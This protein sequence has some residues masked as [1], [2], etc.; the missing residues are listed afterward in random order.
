MSEANWEEIARFPYR[1]VRISTLVR[2]GTAMGYGLDD[3]AVGHEYDHAVLVSRKGIAPRWVPIDLGQPPLQ[4]LT[5]PVPAPEPPP[6]LP[7]A[8]DEPTVAEVMAATD[9]PL[10]RFCRDCGR[11][12]ASKD[13]ARLHED[14]DHSNPDAVTCPT[15]SWVFA[16]DRGLAHHTKMKHDEPAPPI[17]RHPFDPDAARAR[18]ADSA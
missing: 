12:F 3:L 13:D 8:Q 14:T 16:T 6:A 18:A 2:I 7:A 10:T 15:C 17:P 1:L 11:E 5:P 9:L 4:I